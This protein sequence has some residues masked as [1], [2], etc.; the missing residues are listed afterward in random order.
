MSTEAFD[1]NENTNRTPHAPSPEGH[2][3]PLTNDLAAQIAAMKA[4]LRD[5]QRQQDLASAG[6]HLDAAE[7]VEFVDELHWVSR[8]PMREAGNPRFE[9]QLAWLRTNASSMQ[10]LQRYLVAKRG[11]IGDDS[12]RALEASTEHILSSMTTVRADGKLTLREARTLVVGEVQ[13]GKT[14]SMAGVIAGSVDVGA[15]VVIV[16]AGMTNRLRAQT[17]DRLETDMERGSYVLETPTNLLDLAGAT[18]ERSQFSRASV[19]AC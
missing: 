11:S 5:L 16:L 19:H 13:A 9:E 14:T 10:Q 2:S 3:E 18:N 4:K 12:T 6:E 17:H 8:A 7:P 15:R 1:P